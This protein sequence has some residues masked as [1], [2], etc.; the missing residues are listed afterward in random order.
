MKEITFGIYDPTAKQAKAI[1]EN[2]K[3]VSIKLLIRSPRRFYYS[4]LNDADQ[5]FREQFPEY[6]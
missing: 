4:F 1:I 6:V 5:A 3:Y 2:G